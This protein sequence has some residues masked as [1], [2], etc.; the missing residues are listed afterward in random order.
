LISADVECLIDLNNAI[1][2]YQSYLSIELTENFKKI[3][4][5]QER[6]I[7]HPNLVLGKL[8]FKNMKYREARKHFKFVIQNS[9]N[10]KQ[11]AKLKP[12]FYLTTSLQFLG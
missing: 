6:Y 3:D 12:L 10:K 5:S 4:F 7:I 8:L 9:L 1:K 2:L 11:I